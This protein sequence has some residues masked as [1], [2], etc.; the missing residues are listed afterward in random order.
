MAI[1][2]TFATYTFPAADS[3]ARGQSG[4]WNDEEKLI[5]HDP[6]NADVTILASWGF[7]SRT[8]SINGVCGP[9]TRDAM[10]TFQRNGTVGTLI[11]PEGRQVEARIVSAQFNTLI[12]TGR[13]R[14]AIEFK[15][16]S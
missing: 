12:P 15:E 11:D 16:R 2:W 8:R 14:Y 13:Y 9:T 10:R 1:G 7:R 5:E 4:D 6:L 3:P